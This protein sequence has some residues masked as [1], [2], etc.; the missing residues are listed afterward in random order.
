MKPKLIFSYVARYWELLVLLVLVAFAALS[1]TLFQALG[2]LVY[3]PVLIA[4]VAATVLL[5]RHLVFRNTLDKFAHE[6]FIECFW[7]LP[8]SHR[9]YITLGTLLILFIGGCIIA[10]GLVR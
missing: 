1:Q 4:A 6:N 8:S 3:I 10:S 2:T 7:S 9:L 5:I